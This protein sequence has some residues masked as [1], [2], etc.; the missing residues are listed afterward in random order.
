[1]RL[2]D[3]LFLELRGGYGQSS[4]NLTNPLTPTITD[5]F[6]SQRLLA[7][8]GVSGRWQVNP[9]LLFSPKLAYTYFED[10]TRPY[11]SQLGVD[12]PRVSTRLA[13]FK[14]TPAVAQRFDLAGGSQLEA[15]L[16][17]DVAWNLATTTAQGLGALLP[18]AAG[19]DRVR[20]G[21]TGGLAWRTRGGIRL[22]VSGS[23]D[24]LGSS[25]LRTYRTTVLLQVPVR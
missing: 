24:G 21:V 20:V 7:S 9:S 3:Q 13:Q 1:M 11:T 19:T 8:V 25:T 16:A 15:S 5:S 2:V 17:P 12:I 18:V 22:S 4:N 6:G 10:T 23:F 14:F